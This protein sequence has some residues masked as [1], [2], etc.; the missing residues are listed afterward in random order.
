MRYLSYK[1]ILHAYSN[2]ILNI[3]IMYN[4]DGYDNI[5]IGAANQYLLNGASLE[6]F[7]YATNIYG[8][9]INDGS[10]DEQALNYAKKLIVIYIINS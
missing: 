5:F 7:R 4:M 6:N 9:C 1:V 10:I 3:L 8:F 2:K